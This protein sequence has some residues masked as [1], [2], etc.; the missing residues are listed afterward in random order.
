MKIYS[1]KPVL[2]V[3]TCTCFL[4][5][6]TARADDTNSVATTNSASRLVIVKAVY[7]DLSDPS[8][9]SDVTAQ[10]AA[11]VDSN[12]LA[13]D[14]TDDNFGDPASGVTKQLRVD[15]TIDGVPASKSVYERGKLNIT[16]ADKPNPAD[17]NT[18][19]RL[20][21]RSAVYGVLTNDNT[22]DVTTIVT[23]MVQSNS[24][25]LTVN[26][27]EFGD[28]APYEAKQLRVEYTLNGKNGTQ[29]AAEGKPLNL[30]AGNE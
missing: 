22:I 13:V 30:S 9:T 25:A 29:T 3:L 11:M 7:G 17:K 16:V 5:C 10:L 24:L 6:F 19:S 26:D 27:D 21:I 28:P 20:V 4:A 12:S 23:G 15:F 18:P 2:W 8:S 14:A 1:F